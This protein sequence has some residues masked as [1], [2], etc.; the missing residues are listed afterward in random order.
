MRH[1][2][3][4]VGI[5]VAACALCVAAVPALAA[6]SSFVASIP[7]KTI[8]P[9]HPAKFTGKSEEPQ[10]FK[11]GNTI[12]IVC[13]HYTF[14]EKYAEGKTVTASGKVESETPEEIEVAIHYQKC[15]R[16]IK[17]N[18]SEPERDEFVPATFKGNVKIVYNIHRF[19]VIKENGEEEEQEYP[20]ATFRNTAA[21]FTVAPGKQ[22]KV[23]IPEQTVPMKAE[24]DPE[25]EF[26]AFVPSNVF[27]PTSRK[28]FTN[29]EKESLLIE[30]NFKNLDYRFAEETQCN[31]DQSKEDN[32]N[33]SYKGQFT[34]EIP[35]GNLGVA[36]E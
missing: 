15:G 20:H 29:N 5:A 21:T 3:M 13:Q 12:E 10:T 14:P 33:G 25:G 27:T 24:K 6:S 23:L 1:I 31:V 17:A 16:V 8:S 2:R 26:S 22:C 36:E 35:T 11:F 9:E 30:N 34:L 19:V 18:A 4:A 7:K 28:G 32:D